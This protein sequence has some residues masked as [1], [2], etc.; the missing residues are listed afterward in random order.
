MDKIIIIID[1]YLFDVTNY[2]VSH[3][4]GSYILKK[5]HMKDA[6]EEFN[7]VKGH[8]DGYAL[9]LLE[10]YCIGHKDDDGNKIY[11]ND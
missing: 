7:K 4:G 2:C 11:F 9:G 8:S 3:P 10:K 1:D 5:Y 6:T